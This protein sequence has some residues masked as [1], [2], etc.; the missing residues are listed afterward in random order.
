MLVL[1]TK[2][3]FHANDVGVNNFLIQTQIISWWTIYPYGR[4]VRERH[5]TFVYIAHRS[6]ARL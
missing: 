5:R 6:S 2:I 3:N 4:L 1:E